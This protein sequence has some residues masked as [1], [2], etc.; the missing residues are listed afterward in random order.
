MEIEDHHSVYVMAGG[1]TLADVKAHIH[2]WVHD[3]R[4]QAALTTAGV[5]D[6][7]HLS[8]ATNY[9]GTF[10]GYGYIYCASSALYHIL[11]GRQASGL[12]GYL[13]PSAPAVPFTLAP[14]DWDVPLAP[15]D[16][17]ELTDLHY[18]LNHVVPLPPLITTEGTHIQ[19]KP[20]HIEATNQTRYLRVWSV[21]SHLTAHDLWMLAAP[22][23][24]HVEVNLCKER[25]EALL[26]FPEHTPDANFAAFFLRKVVLDD[27]TTLVFRPLQPDDTPPMYAEVEHY[28]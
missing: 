1:N 10:L 17:V 24:Y 4:V 15:V 5:S 14:P 27:Q 11:L 23:S 28:P 21:P 16:W 2:A 9:E 12:A 19:L 3:P 6:A 18:P 13:E 20:A 8:L 25:H 7:Y 26:V 22:Y